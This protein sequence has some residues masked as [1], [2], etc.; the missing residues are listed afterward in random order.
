MSL[1]DRRGNGRIPGDLCAGEAWE[2]KVSA[3]K[4]HSYNEGNRYHEVLEPSP[5]VLLAL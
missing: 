2:T 5:W 3:T 4:H 1:E